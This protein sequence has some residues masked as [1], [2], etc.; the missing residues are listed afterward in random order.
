MTSTHRHLDSRQVSDLN[1]DLIH[2]LMLPFSAP[3]ETPPPQLRNTYGT[4]PNIHQDVVNTRTVVNN[5]HNMLKGQEGAGYQPL[6]VSVTHTLS[7]TEYT[8]TVS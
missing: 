7:L 3:G 1:Y 2:H 5:I 4:V 6:L 8:F